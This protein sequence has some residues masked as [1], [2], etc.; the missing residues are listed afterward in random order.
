VRTIDELGE[1]TE[2][3]TSTAEV[4]IRY[5]VGPEA[6]AEHPSRDYEADLDL[7]GLPVTTLRPEPWWRRDPIDWVA[8]RVC[9]YMDLAHRA[10]DRRPWVLTGEVVGYG[11]DHEPLIGAVQPLAWIGERAL[12]QASKRYHERFDV[13]RDSTGRS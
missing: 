8:R 1:L 3:A 11:P 4:Y 12:E 2:L 10:P 7:P 5:S 13:G 6:D 9:K